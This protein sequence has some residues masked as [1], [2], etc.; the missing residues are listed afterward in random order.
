MNTDSNEPWVLRV[1]DGKTE[2]VPVTLGLTDPRTERVLLTVRRDRRDVAAAR[3]PRRAFT[4]GTPVQVPRRTI[5][6]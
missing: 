6:S 3:S 5:R 4:P 1:T 2:R